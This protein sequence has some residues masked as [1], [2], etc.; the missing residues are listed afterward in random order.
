MHFLPGLSV[1]DYKV[2]FFVLC[3]P[4]V[5]TD[6]NLISEV[7]A[8]SLRVGFPFECCLLCRRV[9]L[10]VACID[11]IVLSDSYELVRAPAPKK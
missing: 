6:W 8:G 9:S 2:K 5:G 1:F 7:E 11:S 10:G 4:I 3:V